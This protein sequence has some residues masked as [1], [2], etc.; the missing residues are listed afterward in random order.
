MNNLERQKIVWEVLTDAK[1][2]M[3][4]TPEMLESVLRR[5]TFQQLAQLASDVWI[6]A[7][8][9]SPNAMVNE[10]SDAGS[11]IERVVVKAYRL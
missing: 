5:M 2:T 10:M 1:G 7:T 11:K 9:K 6:V 8:D 3:S 4:Q